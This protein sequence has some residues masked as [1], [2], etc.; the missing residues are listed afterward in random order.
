[1][2]SYRYWWS[3]HQP[4]NIPTPLGVTKEDNEPESQTKLT[5]TVPNSLFSNTSVHTRRR[6]GERDMVTKLKSK[7]CPL[8]TSIR[9]DAA[10]GLFEPQCYSYCIQSLLFPRISSYV[11]STNKSVSQYNAVFQ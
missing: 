11:V 1:M 9:Q 7:Y 5:W 4:Q 2:K 8:K 6:E 10:T 3:A